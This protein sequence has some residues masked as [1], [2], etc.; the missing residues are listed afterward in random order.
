MTRFV[1][2][3]LAGAFM[4][5]S[6]ACSKNREEKAGAMLTE[7]G[8]MRSDGNWVEKKELLNQVISEY[9]E[10]QS[11]GMATIMLNKL[12]L[13]CNRTA[14]DDL[15]NALLAKERYLKEHPD[16]IP[17]IQAL[18]EYGFR[19]SNGVDPRII[20]NGEGNPLIRSEHVAGDTVYSGKKAGD[21]FMTEKKE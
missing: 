1:T 7:I 13:S 8:M 9:P 2:L 11:A 16:G 14:Q 19:K 15:Q 12:I 5:T 18:R 3:F 17:D 21:E 10:T 4:I 6:L 20:R